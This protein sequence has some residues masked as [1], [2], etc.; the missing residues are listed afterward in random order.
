VRYEAFRRLVVVTAAGAALWTT[1]AWA[2]Q[3]RA[4]VDTAGDL[5]SLGGYVREGDPNDGP[6]IEGAVVT[7]SDGQVA[8]TN[9]RGYFEFQ[10]IP[11]GE[12][13]ISVE[14]E[15]YEPSAVS[16]YVEPDMLN[17]QNVA[18]TP[19]PNCV[20]EDTGCAAPARVLPPGAEGGGDLGAGALWVVGVGF[21]ATGIRRAG[22]APRR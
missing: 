13:V 2:V 5:G 14:A 8:F 12:Y 15:C 18:L 11:A 10:G 6:E 4:G 9:G 3:D 21:L 19:I 16:A 7:L 22:R 17:I 1:V 20:P